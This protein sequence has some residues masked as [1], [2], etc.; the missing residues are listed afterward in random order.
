MK[1]LG[2]LKAAPPVLHWLK[3]N[4]VGLIGVGVQLAALAFFR[5]VLD[6]NYLVATGLAVE[7]AVLHN[8]VWHERWTWRERDH[9]RSWR[10]IISRLTGFHL[11]SGLISILGNLLLMRVLAG[12]LGLQYLVANAIT[13]A[14][15]STANFFAADRL[16]FRAPR[17]PL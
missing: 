10:G 5:R 17:R 1:C 2:S 4:A 16:V 9:D 7:T 11:T 13:I 6:L 15:L 12:A 14:I 8:F 3:F